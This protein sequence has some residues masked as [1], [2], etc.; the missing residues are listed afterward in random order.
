MQRAGSLVPL[1]VLGTAWILQAVPALT[2]PL[3]LTQESFD[4]GRVSG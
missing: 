1:L 4:L 3:I 2:E